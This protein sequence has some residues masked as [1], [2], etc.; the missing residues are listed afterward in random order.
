[1]TA[2]LFEVTISHD[3]AET[4]Y[5]NPGHIVVA[6]SVRDDRAKTRLTMVRGGD[7]VLKEPLDSFVRRL[8]SWERNG[9]E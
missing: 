7:V 9:G 6:R 4:V 3:G 5:I 2:D 8:D 1:V